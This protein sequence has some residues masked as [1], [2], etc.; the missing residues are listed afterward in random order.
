MGIIC[1]GGGGV[2]V[3]V[4]VCLSQLCTSVLTQLSPRQPAVVVRGQSAKYTA[5]NSVPLSANGHDLWLNMCV[6]VCVFV[7]VCVC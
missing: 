6:C 1:G 5:V 3:C 2:C 7:C 4:C